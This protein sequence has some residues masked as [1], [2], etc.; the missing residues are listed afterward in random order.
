VENTKSTT[1]V[2]PPSDMALAQDAQ[3][4]LG[5]GVDLMIRGIPGANI[6][7]GAAATTLPA[8]C[9]QNLLDCCR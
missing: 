8:G 7:F 2:K 5:H 4:I 6:D 1:L 9:R 3:I